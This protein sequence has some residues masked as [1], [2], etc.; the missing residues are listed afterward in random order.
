MSIEDIRGLT[1][2]RPWSEYIADGLKPL[3]NRNWTPWKSML[4][5]Y[6]AIHASARW[7][8]E[9]AD[10][11]ER[12]RSRFPFKRPKAMEECKT[13]IIAVARLV[14]WI[15]IGP[16]GPGQTKTIAMLPGHGY[17]FKTDGPWF[18]GRYGW[19]LRDVVRIAPL[20]VKGKQGL[21]TL[22]PDTYER[23]RRRYDNARL[24][25]ERWKVS[26]SGTGT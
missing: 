26:P 23:V 20:E 7:D 8:G 9:G 22:D 14:G 21:W 6:L 1:V 15:E 17:Q 4:G 16:H 24:R 13:G 10:F 2:Y 11:I 12:A 3:E 19:L 25:A 18:F 5:K